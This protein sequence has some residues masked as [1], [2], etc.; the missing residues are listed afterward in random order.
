MRLKR[1]AL[2]R[3]SKLGLGGL[4]LIILGT[5]VAA[6][7]G[8]SGDKS[9]GPP[10][11][12][13]SGPTRG[14]FKAETLRISA[15]PDQDPE[16]L[17]RLY[18]ALST[19]LTTT[20]GVK[21]DYVPVTDY[22]AS[23]SS[24]R[25]GDL[26]AV[27]FGGLTGVQARLQTPGATPLAQRDIDAQFRS[28]FIASRA[29]GLAAVT[30]VAGLGAIKGHSLTFGSESSTSGRLMP[31]F[32]LDQA[33]VSEADLKGNPGFSGAHD[34]TIKLVESGTYEVGALNKQVWDGA[35]A[36]GSVDLSKVALIFETPP[37]ADY[38]WLARPN[39]DAKFGA[40]FTSALR[41]SILA[42]D[43][44]NPDQA[45]VLELFGAKR[46]VPTEAERYGRIE[47]IGR[48]LGLIT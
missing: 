42:L 30:S 6:G 18:G 11:T 5:L 33:G 10:A 26:D 12:T 29:S 21:V 3:G 24:F 39:L 15:I 45:A 9:A 32:F 40:G 41:E 38:H 8:S 17:N 23:V 13:S 7:C 1:D 47:S 25:I 19:Y 31:Q 34:A 48:K 27:W 2:K 44:K 22:T 28:V 16:K 20:L 37:F 46:F 14:T 36:D 35:V 4:T 43:A